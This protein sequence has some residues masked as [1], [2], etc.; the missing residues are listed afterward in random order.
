VIG[1]PLSVP[2][3]IKLNACN[4]LDITNDR[5]LACEAEYPTPDGERPKRNRE[6]LGK[7]GTKVYV[8]QL[9][10]KRPRIF[11]IGSTRTVPST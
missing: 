4:K 5:N 9:R 8:V 6:T 11:N 7:Y 1:K 2:I 10:Q 3:I